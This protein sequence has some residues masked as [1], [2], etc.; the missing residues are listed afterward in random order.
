MSSGAG[1]FFADLLNIFYQ[2]FAMIGSEGEAGISIISKMFPEAINKVL[3]HQDFVAMYRV[4]I[5]IG[6]IFSVLYYSLDLMDNVG[7]EQVSIEKIVLSFSKLIAGVALVS[8]GLE[9]FKGLN[10]FSILAVEQIN[11]ALGI[12]DLTGVVGYSTT[13]VNAEVMKSVFGMLKFLIAIFNP[14]AFLSMLSDL[15]IILIFVFLVPVIAYQRAVK[16]GMYCLLA[17][18]ALSDTVGKGAFSIRAIKFLINLFKAFMEFPIIYYGCYL[19]F[20]LNQSGDVF[21]DLSIS[22]FIVL[23]TVIMNAKDTIRTLVGVQNG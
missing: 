13:E 21:A 11:A 20:E 18:I 17:P 23:I 6:I 14:L 7:F 22:F 15:L 1:R 8:N 12:E 2:F 19:A 9:I 10:G 3:N 5:P 4:M 16:I